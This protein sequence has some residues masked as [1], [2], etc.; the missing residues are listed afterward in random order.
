MILLYTGTPGSGKS[1]HATRDIYD[2]V[3]FKKIPVVANYG[4]NLEGVEDAERY[5]NYVQN[6]EL[7]P[8]FLVA[9]ADDY[10]GGHEFREEGILCVVDE[11]QL[12]WNSRTWDDRARG[13]KYAESMRMKWLEFFSQHRKYGYKIILIAQDDCMI[14]KQFRVLLEYEVNHRN[15][16]NYGLFGLFLNVITFGRH[17]L[18]VR[19]YYGK[20]DR[21]DS[22]FI[23]FRKKYSRIYNSYKAFEQGSRRQG[24]DAPAAVVPS[25]L[26]PSLDV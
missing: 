12:L 17:F 10:W 18:A 9:F 25:K 21:L 5:F 22:S 19:Y 8:D 24:A 4:L 7:N 6:S 13:E 3:R 2:A 11:C 1:Y 23:R 20:H 26:V 16:S 15:C 14:D